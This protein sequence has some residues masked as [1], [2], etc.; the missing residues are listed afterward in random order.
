MIQVVWLSYDEKTPARG[1]WDHGMLERL[2]DNALWQPP[3]GFEFTHTEDLSKAKDGCVIVLPAR[4]QAEYVDRLN[5][6]IKRLKWVLVILT[7]DEESV[8]PFEKIDHP[9][10]RLWVMS[11]RAK[12]EGHRFLGTGYPPQAIPGL[13]NA[14]MEYTLKPMDYFFAGQVTHP[15]RT[16]CVEQLRAMGERDDLEGDYLATEGFTQGMRPAKYYKMLAAA[17]I[18]PA[19]SGPETPD[20]FRV[21]EALE[22]G[23]IPVV[24]HGPDAFDMPD[25]WTF[26]FG[27]QPPFPVV[28]DYEQLHGYTL[29]MVSQWPAKGIEVYAWWQAKKREMAYNLALDIMHLTGA[30]PSQKLPSEQVTVLIPTSP[31]L[32]HPKTHMIEET[33]TTVRHHLPNC[34]IIL[35][36][37]G[38]RKE[39]KNLQKVYD[40][41]RRIL[42]WKCNFEWHNV[43]PLVFSEHTHQA[44]MT[45]RALDLVNTPVV[46]FV[47]HDTPVVTDEPIPWED[48]I[49]SIL[50]GEANIIRL[51]HEAGVLPEHE[52]LMLDDKPSSSGPAPMRKT[53]QWSQRPHLANVAFYKDILDRYF[54][55]E[56]RTMIE[57]HIHGIVQTD[58]ITDRKLGWFKWRLWIYAPEG[59]MKRSYHLDG[60]G[61]EPKY[62]MKT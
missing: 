36:I 16:E 30:T 53:M 14:Y 56:S 26:F 29:D 23:C 3:G 44:G 22:A 9:N 52:P 50:G 8:F 47:E 41:Y 48:L 54:R 10:M 62:E 34:E 18:A 35:M 4:A 12:H 17:K 40:E 21:F 43:L 60:R 59:N 7:G 45:R 31:I 1:Y 57:D 55:P 27:E 15:R 25:Y 37:D 11:P 51:H 28:T 38:V 42:L 39:Q 6:D 61:N 13:S 49:E 33:I 32:L 20:S 5:E 58:C 2:L 19:P 46:M 24:D